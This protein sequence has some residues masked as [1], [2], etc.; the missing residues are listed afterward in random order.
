MKRIIAWLPDRVDGRTRLVAWIYLGAQIMLVATGGAVRL[1][2]SGLGCPTWP[3]CTDDSL[4]NTPEMGVHGFIE[5]GNRLLGGVLAILAIIAFLQ[6][7]K[8]YR[9]RADLFRLAL[10]AGLVWG[11]RQGVQYSL[12]LVT[13]KAL[14]VLIIG[15]FSSITGAIV[16]GLLVGA[17]ES[18]ADIYIGPLVQGSVSTW[19]AYILAV[20]F[21]LVRPAGLFGDRAIE[22]V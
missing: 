3:K 17:T 7:V 21:L 9:R 16:G 5:F 2:S 1:T 11:A 10:V 22:R 4:V 15:G 20:A 13:L 12:S 8:L 19:F 18:L 6:V 14:P